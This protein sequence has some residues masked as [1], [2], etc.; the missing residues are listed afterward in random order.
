MS[1]FLDAAAFG[2]SLSTDLKNCSHFHCAVSYIRQSGI[3]ALVAQ[4]PEQIEHSQIVTC[5]DFGITEPSA[6]RDLVNRGYRVRSYLKTGLHSKVWVLF[7]PDD[8]LPV[9]YVGS[10]NLSHSAASSNIEGNIRTQEPETVEEAIRWLSTLGSSELVSDIDLAWIDAYEKVRSP[11][12]PEEEVL[13]PVASEKAEFTTPTGIWHNRS[14]GKTF[15]AQGILEGVTQACPSREQLLR[16][17]QIDSAARVVLLQYST[18][19]KLHVRSTIDATLNRTGEST[20]QLGGGRRQVHQWIGDVWG[21]DWETSS[22]MNKERN[23]QNW[24]NSTN[25][26]LDDFKYEILVDLKDLVPTIWVRPTLK[27]ES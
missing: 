23:W 3:G 22:Q 27:Q 7:F 18:S 10:S 8:Q 6:L 19:N 5:T 21:F 15:L 25:W 13:P 2:T 24:F 26:N 17:T 16:R 11:V 9:L 4:C 1:T 12:E 14:G 20:V